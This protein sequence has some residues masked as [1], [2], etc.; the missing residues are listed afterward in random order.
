VN[1]CLPQGESGSQRIPVHRRA[2]SSDALIVTFGKAFDGDVDLA[3][4]SPGARRVLAVAAALFFERGAA[5]TSVR[6]IT[7]A[8]GLS[9]G[10][11][12]NHFAS[13]DDVLY[14]LVRHGHAR[15]ER[16]VSASLAAADPG[17]PVARF[18]AF[19]AAYVTG[20]LRHPEL[21]QVVRRE[22]LHLDAARRAQIV[23]RRRAM[24]TRL[25]RVLRDGAVAGSFDLLDGPRGATGVA[26]MVLD[27]CSRT[28][29]WYDPARP[30]RPERLVE[31]YV[32]G[33]LRLA[34]ATAGATA[35]GRPPQ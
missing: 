24:R 34:G 28:S 6:D 10:A 31:R 5:A 15:L 3:H 33:A 20:H 16:R 4:L 30:G 35:E 25:A 13:R 1:D 32:S 19:V 26:V 12:Y 7:R 11:L 22:Y 18:S 21:A 23:D 14:E 2:G 9:P 29:E 8:C 17:D 27:M